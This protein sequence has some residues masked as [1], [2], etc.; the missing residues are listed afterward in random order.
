M[1][2]IKES[3]SGIEEGLFNPQS[4]LLCKIHIV[5]LT[6]KSFYNKTLTLIQA[7]TT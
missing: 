4:D 2:R 6:K 1:P 7:G 5:Q 3:K